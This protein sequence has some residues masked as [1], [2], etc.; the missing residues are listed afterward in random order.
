[1]RKVILALALLGIAGSAVADDLSG[2]AFICHNVPN[3][4]YTTWVEEFSGQAP[5][6]W[7]CDQYPPLTSCDDQVNEIYSEEYTFY[8][9]FY[10]LV[11]WADAKTFCAAEFGLGGYDSGLI[12][13]SQHGA[14]GI[15]PQ[16]IPTTDPAWPAP[17]SG[18]A[19]AWAADNA[20]SG[21]F[22]P[23]YFFGCYLYGSYY[24]S[25]TVPLTEDPAQEFI[26]TAS[27]DV[28][29]VTYPAYDWGTFGLN[30]AGD[31]ACYED[32]VREACCFDADCVLLTMEECEAQEG[33]WAGGPCDPNPCLPQV[34][35]CCV[36]GQCEVLTREECAEAGGTYQ[37]DETTCDPNP[38][39][40][41][42][43]YEDMPARGQMACVV[44][45]EEDC[46][47][48]FGG[49]FHPDEGSCE[50]NPCP[51]LEGAC[52]VIG[53][54]SVTTEP[55]CEQMGG[56]YQGDYESCDPNPCEAVCCY[57]EIPGRGQMA[58]VVTLE[59]E[60]HPRP[61]SPHA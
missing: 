10:V 61:Y 45:L 8:D 41:V 44:T 28:P 18:I 56:I 7:W 19:I 27:C 53:V 14:C 12:S 15:D 40:A 42:C 54:C 57:T 55:D 5:L 3:L 21:N 29:P 46:A 13:F 39:E 35:A 33:E 26:G 60:E 1:M 34:G 11:A 59:G 32:V 43:C 23:V 47:T 50:P 58:C 49:I 6:N 22:L 9:N 31:P 2:G 51:Q 16:T 52:C 36:I 38:C 20:P 30:E 24:G 4:G 17:N 37:G 48:S 25:T